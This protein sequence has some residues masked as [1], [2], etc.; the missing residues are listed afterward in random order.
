MGQ[1]EKVPQRAYRRSYEQ[2]LL[3]RL[4][5]HPTPVHSRC[6]GTPAYGGIR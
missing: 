1:Q 3:D 6:Y 5:G 2:S 4:K